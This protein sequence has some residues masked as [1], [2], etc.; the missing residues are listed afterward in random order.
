[1]P[2]LYFLVLL[3]FLFL[4]TLFITFQ[5]YN[6]FIFELF[7]KNEESS[8]IESFEINQFFYFIK[9]LLSKKCWFQ[10]LKLLESQTNIPFYKMAEYFNVVGFIYY[11]MNQ[12]HLAELYYKVSLSYKPGYAIT[13]KNLSR[14]KESKKKV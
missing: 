1:M 2:Y 4:F 12:F 8:I 7:I 14:I 10:S 5:L 9:C 11:K 3:I 6:F 13:L